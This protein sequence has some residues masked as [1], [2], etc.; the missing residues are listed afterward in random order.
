VVLVYGMTNVDVATILGPNTPPTLSVQV[1][2]W[3]VD[4]DLA[5][6]PVA[7]AAAVLQVALVLAALAL[8]WAGERLAAALGRRWVWR[9]AALPERASRAAGFT[10]GLAAA[11]AVLGGLAALA[12]W[13][14]AAGWRFPDLA[15]DA[16][17]ARSWARFGPEMARVAADTMA[18]AAAAVL[19]SLLLT[20]GCLEAEHRFGLTTGPRALWLLYLPLLIPQ[21]AFLPGMVS[22]AAMTG[23]GHGWGLVLAGHVVFVLPYVFLSLQGPFRAWDT[24]LARVAAGLG[25]GPDQV[26]WRLRL[27]M[28]AGPVLTAAAVGTAV[29]VG[30]YLPT[31]LLGGGRVS[32]L[33]TEAV[34]LA[35]G[36]DRRAIGVWGLGQTLA[37]LLPFALATAV[38]A[39]LWRRRRGLRVVG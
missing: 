31:L 24:R 36:G 14:V 6:R 18:L 25:A 20:V 17:T 34:A 7:A 38:P 8:W 23:T 15:P 1:T 29:S 33:T 30:Q 5:L 4:P 35:A 19:V 26:L 22:A 28:L 16:L 27:P 3:M 9:G 39:L 13:S 2:R 10:L 37:A 11:A 21:V 32:T 12:L